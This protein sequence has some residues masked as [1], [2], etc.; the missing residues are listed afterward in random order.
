MFSRRKMRDFCRVAAAAQAG[1]PRRAMGAAFQVPKA[2]R[3]EIRRGVPAGRI[4]IFF[5]FFLARRAALVRRRSIAPHGNRVA[6]GLTPAGIRRAASWVRS[7]LDLVAG[8]IPAGSAKK[9]NRNDRAGSRPASRPR[10]EPRTPHGFR[11]WLRRQASDG[12]ILEGGVADGSR[13]AKKK[14]EAGLGGTRGLAALVKGNGPKWSAQGQERK[15]EKERPIYAALGPAVSIAQTEWEGRRGPKGW[16]EAR[17]KAKLPDAGWTPGRSARRPGA[18]A[19]FYGNGKKRGTRRQA[20]RGMA[21]VRVT[22]LFYAYWD[23]TRPIPRT[24]HTLAGLQG[25]GSSCQTS[26]EIGA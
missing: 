26:G 5:F 1:P 14:K 3:L 13:V 17:A 2:A 22:W 16:V 12:P 24:A 6:T 23:W 25:R 9:R 19:A 20:G 8:R 7:A 10:H 11:S 4:G 18:T 15:K 21:E